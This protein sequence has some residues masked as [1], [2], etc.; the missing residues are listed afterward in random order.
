MIFSKL[1]NLS[2]QNNFSDS[3]FVLLYNMLGDDRAVS[4]ATKAKMLPFIAKACL[5]SNI[6]TNIWKPIYKKFSNRNNKVIEALDIAFTAFK[7][8][9]IKKAFLSENFGALLSSNSD[10][11]VFASGDVDC[12]VDPSEYEKVSM[13]FAELG[14]LRKER[15]SKNLLI[16]SEFSHDKILP[17]NFSIG[18]DLFPLSRLSMPCFIQT[19]N[20]VDWNKMRRYGTT[21]IV[22]PPIE[23]LMYI[24]L[25]HI[26]LHSFCRA[27]A[28]RLYR[29]IVNCAI[30]MQNNDWQSILKWAER[31]RV[32]SRISMAAYISSII[33]KVKI[34]PEIIA[35]LNKQIFDLVF[36]SDDGI[37]RDEPDRINVLKI[38]ALCNDNSI[39]DGIREIVFPDSA[40]MTEVYGENNIITE[41]KHIFDIL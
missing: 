9:G 23:A 27:P 30:G 32:R 35:L 10:F 15:Y 5:K 31:D 29:D 3:E 17:E 34:P 4:M 6:S 20:F 2:I 40:W 38:E 13:A 22:L 14:F 11:A 19:D 39:I 21:A 36:D 26:S 25:L 12:Y 16:S 18:I 1:C 37:L 33:G 41:I 8:Y 28:V 24:C 7:K